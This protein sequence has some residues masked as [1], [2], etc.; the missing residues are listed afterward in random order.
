MASNRDWG[1]SPLSSTV[2]PFAGP[3]DPAILEV[4]GADIPADLQAFYTAL[5][6][7]VVAAII[8]RFNA[9]F[10]NYEALL[11]S[12]GNYAF[13]ASAVGT[14]A[15]AYQLTQ[16]GSTAVVNAGVNS[17]LIWRFGAQADR[18]WLNVSEGRGCI[19]DVSSLAPTAA[20]GA[21]TVTL[22]IASVDLIAGRAYET[23]SL[24]NWSCS[25]VART[26]TVRVRLTNIA[27]AEATVQRTPALPVFGDFAGA[28]LFAKFQV[29]SSG[30]Y[31]L[32]QT[33]TAT[34]G[35]IVDSAAAPAL[36]RRLEI[37][38]VGAAVRFSNLN[39]V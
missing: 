34:T 29:N 2:P 15:E 33:Q 5:G 25:A 17:P 18:Q 35:T 37:W 30:N 36:P 20:I 39:A 4:S 24:G 38:D 23:R 3:N 12:S 9:N 26:A 6:T 16:S 21:E 27:G 1:V 31:V 10:Y 13:G 14:V 8:Y 7:P 19:A 22:T 28:T 32:V 11:N